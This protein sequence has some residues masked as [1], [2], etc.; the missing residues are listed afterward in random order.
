VKHLLA[1][2]ALLVAGCVSQTQPA[3]ELAAAAREVTVVA[4]DGVKLR[5]R[6][7]GAGPITVI[8]PLV[9]WNQARF[10]TLSAPI[11][12][13]FYDPR[14]RGNSDR[15]PAESLSIDQD[16]RDLDAVRR[17]FGLE[18]VSLIGTSY[19]GGMVARY[20]MLHPQRVER[21]VM[22]GPI[23][24]RSGIM[25]GY[26]PPQAAERVN[27]EAVAALE[28]RRTSLSSEEYC[29][30][31][32]ALYAPL[33]VGRAEDAPK[34]LIRCELSNEQPAS[35]FPSLGAIMGSV[36][37]FDWTEDAKKVT[38]PA[39]IIHGTNDLV[40]PLEGSR[41]WE[42]ILPEAKLHVLAGGGHVPWY[43]DAE[44]IFPAVINFLEHA[45]AVE[46]RVRR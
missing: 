38:A 28:Q 39:L 22:V 37:T 25:A 14:N 12:F 2:A 26:S 35:L 18:K 10:G 20:A 15:V 34:L 7:V 42:R 9:D 36:G 6:V 24:P 13:I 1:V 11:R 46:S 21:L 43:D 23:P 16:L 17:H 45:L 31:W 30:Q 40:V 19:Y 29:R 33:Y 4:D 5:G 3:L 32:W 41:E 27:R 8:A 44:R